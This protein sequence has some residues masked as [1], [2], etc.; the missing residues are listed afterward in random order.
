MENENKNAP[1]NTPTDVETI[2][3]LKADHDALYWK[4]SAKSADLYK[5]SEIAFK[6]DPSVIESL[7]DEARNK[8]TKNTFWIETYEEALAVLWPDFYKK[9]ENKNKDV[10]NNSVDEILAEFQKEKKISE[11]RL[12]TK[13]EELAIDTYLAKNT[14]I[15][16]KVEW[17]KD[18]IKIEM[19]KLSDALQIENKIEI[20]STLVK[21]QTSNKVDFA[22][23]TSWA[24]VTL[25]DKTLKR[26]SQLASIFG[27][28]I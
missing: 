17:A 2:N 28:K 16:D 25:T 1:A 3:K 21:V 24:P 19:K 8:I 12:K 27:N 23:T 26:N 7:P 11:Y 10:D 4:Y 6:A 18:L 13:E 20:A 5:V 14:T 15:F 9:S 22:N